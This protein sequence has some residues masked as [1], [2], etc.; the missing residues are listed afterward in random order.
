M[1]TLDLKY[2][3]ED[4][5]EHAEYENYLITH[6]NNVKKAYTWL[7]EHIPDILS[8][9]NYA[10]EIAYY[11]ELDDIIAKHDSSKY[12]KIP[13]AENYY[14]LKCE[15][16]QYS[17]YFYGE[18]TPEVKTRFDYA[19]LS[20]I[21]DNPHHW[22]HWLLQ[23][24]DPNIGLRVLDMPY[25]FIIEMICDWWSFGWKQNKLDELFTWYENNKSGIILSPKT[26]KTV[27]HIL[28]EIK[29]ELNNK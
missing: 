5:E 1:N 25:V 2:L 28:D 24:D 12:N 10:D 19:W 16:D 14:E 15:Y 3:L 18:K 8:E 20:H 7:K 17:D 27:E 6:I 26:R 23:N 21:H 9:H 13:D 29:K 4:L 22:Q 11:G